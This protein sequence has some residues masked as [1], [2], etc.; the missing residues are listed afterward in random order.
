MSVPE[1]HITVTG[2]TLN[3]AL[4]SA[5]SQLGIET[6]LVAYDYDRDHFTNENGRPKGVFN[7]Q[8]LAWKLDEKMIAGAESA[9]AWLKTL[10]DLIGIET[11]VRYDIKGDKK[12]T[13][14][15]DTEQAGRIVG[16]KGASL[17]SISYIFNAAMKQEHGDWSFNIDVT[18]GQ[19]NDNESSRDSGSRGRKGK[20]D[21]RKLESRANRLASKVLKT[22]EALEMFGELNSFERRIVH[23]TVQEIEGVTSKSVEVDGVKKIHILPA[24][25]ED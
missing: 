3:E 20:S 9:Q 15:L 21:V 10:T 19:R 23:Q 17:Q 7:V 4:S 8:I 6:E 1:N 18:G 14:V 25:Q 5:A 12:A 11:K 22:G 13:L 2:T 16:R 24:E